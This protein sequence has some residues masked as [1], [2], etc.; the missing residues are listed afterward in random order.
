MYYYTEAIGTT[1]T[2]YQGK[3]FDE[4]Q[5]VQI[6][7]SGG[8]TSTE[9]EDFISI[10]GYDHFASNPAYSGGSVSLNNSNNYTIKFYYTRQKFPI[11]YMDGA[12]YNGRDQRLTDQTSTGQIHVASD[13]TYGSDISNYKNYVPTT[14]PA[15]FVFEGWYAD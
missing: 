7:T 11:N 14:A 12:Y 9:A 5:H 10:L 13:V 2:Y 15:G 6:S 1:S 4:H 3:Y 8:I